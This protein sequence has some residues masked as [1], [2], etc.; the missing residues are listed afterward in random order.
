MKVTARSGICCRANMKQI[1]EQRT[2]RVFGAWSEM[3]LETNCRLM[4]RPLPVCVF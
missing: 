1:T 3:S 4:R 2:G